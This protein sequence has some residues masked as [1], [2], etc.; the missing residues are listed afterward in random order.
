MK[1]LLE[2]DAVL[3]AVHYCIHIANIYVAIDLSL[4]LSLSLSLFL[5]CRKYTHVDKKNGYSGTGDLRGVCSC[6]T[7]KS[8]DPA[9]KQFGTRGGRTWLTFSNQVTD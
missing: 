9:D 1:Q 7:G 3:G 5:L 8:C 4:S 6:A 2:A